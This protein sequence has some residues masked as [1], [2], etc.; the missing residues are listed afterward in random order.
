M[1]KASPLTLV[2][3]SPERAAYQLDYESRLQDLPSS[4]SFKNHLKNLSSEPH[5]FGSEANIRVGEYISDAMDRAGL[6]VER[7]PYDVYVPEPGGQIEVALVTPNRQPLNG[8]ENIVKDD[9]YSSHPNLNHGWNA[10]SGSGE[11]TGE[12][13]YANYGTK[14]DFEKLLELDIR[15]E[16][17]IV[18][19]RFGGNFRGHK[20]K[21]ACEH[22]ALGILMYSDPIDGGYAQGTVYP[23]GKFL[24]ESA[25]QRGALLTLGYVGD[26]LTPFEPAYPEDGRKRTKRL[27]PDQLSFPTIPVAPLPYGSAKQIL[28]KMEGPG[29]P[30]GWQGGLPFPYRLAGGPDLTVRMK[31]DQPRKLTRATNVVGTIEGTECPDE[32]VILGCHYD[33]WEFGTADPNSGTAMLLTLAD[34]LGQ[35]QRDGQAPR[36]TIKIGHW[37]AEEY[38]IIGS[39]EWV[40]QFHDELSKK[41]VAYINA[42]MAA[43]GPH[44]GAAAS[45]SLKRPIFDATRAVLYPGTDRSVFDTWRKEAD[46]PNIGNLGGGSDHIAFYMHVGIPSAG[47]GM[48]GF[49]PYHTAYDNLAWYERFADPDYVFGPAVAKVHGVL[50]TRLANADILPYDL[51][52]YPS[53]LLEHVEALEKR[54]DDLNMPLRLN[55]MKSSIYELDQ[56]AKGFQNVCKRTFPT[57][58]LTDKLLTQ[59]NRS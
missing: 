26:P 27:D 16:G 55:L 45:P 48:G 35:L 19:A 17:R 20:A 22:G 7:F 5:P 10:Y 8:Q 58:E 24:N 54:S 46:T 50:A 32:W 21:Y 40:E 38:N 44:F 15:I 36:R 47:L 56:A 9:V 23:E 1:S 3:F 31:V 4:E 11:V 6:E 53:D 34:T 29:V 41:A 14:E 25:V 59:L 2:G 43:C 51:E 49:T 37:D 28:D 33:A 12:I 30:S 42:D 18:I 52:S 57:G 39:T 13:V